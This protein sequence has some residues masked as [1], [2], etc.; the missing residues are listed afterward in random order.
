MRL[1]KDRLIA[2]VESLEIS[3]K[4]TIE[5]HSASQDK[6]AQSKFEKSTAGALS[7]KGASAKGTESQPGGILKM[8]KKPTPI[9]TRERFNPALNEVYEPAGAQMTL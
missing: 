6:L 9:P 7:A 1:E 5:D 8:T 2:K 4:Q 3:L